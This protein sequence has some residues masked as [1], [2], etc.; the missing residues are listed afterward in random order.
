[1]A[2]SQHQKTKPTAADYEKLGR[3]IEAALIDDYIELLGNTR[4]QLRL[5]LLRGIAMGLGS[6]IGATVVVALIVWVLHLFGGLPVIGQL[7]QT[8][9]TQIKN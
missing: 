9:G 1:M 4:R 8:T 3:T 5:S 6:V 2:P 7:L